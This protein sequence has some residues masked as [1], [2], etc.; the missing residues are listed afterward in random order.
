MSGEATTLP[1]D[2]GRW[3][4]LG[5]RLRRSREYLGLS[6]G[7]V[8]EVL[9][10]SRPAIT[11]IEAGRRK[12]STLELAK[13][14][15]LFGQPYEHFLGEVPELV[16]DETS[17]ALFRAARDLTD[18]DR[19]QVL[20][21][22]Q[23]LRNAGRAP[24]P[25]GASLAMT[26]VAQRQQAR[27]K[28][29]TKAVQRWVQLG[30]DPNFSV[31]IFSVIEDERVWLLF[32]PL[33]GLFGFFDRA[34][35]IAG[36]VIQSKHPVRCSLLTA[37]HE[38]GHYVLGHA[39]SQ[40]SRK[41]LFS[42]AADLALQEIEAQA[43]A[44]E[45]MM[46]LAL[47]NR[48][49]DRLDLP[50]EPRGM[51]AAAAYQLSSSSSPSSYTAALTQLRQL[52][53]LNDADVKRLAKREPIDI[54]MELGDGVKPADS[55]AGAWLIEEGDE[56]PPGSPT[57]GRRTARV[58]L[59]FLERIPLGCRGRRPRWPHAATEGQ[60]RAERPRSRTARGRRTAPPPL[61]ARYEPRKRNALRCACAG[62]DPMRGVSQTCS[63]LL[64]RSTNLASIWKLGRA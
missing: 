33:D 8:A 1:P 24:A 30:L 6:Q 3:R 12:V 62:V 10:I 7:E 64:S 2:E 5:E 21:F 28:G 60:S 35:D 14:A 4:E 13:L 25:E 51:T 48:A 38:Y 46:P 61:V 40:D 16:E 15:R 19:Q 17:Q 55:R 52:N 58:R 9:G 59:R 57:H 32:E 54:K 31:D 42:S 22:A 41:E 49:L 63:T 34:D 50:R 26:T 29:S 36:I 27:L 43:F 47:V 23:F 11:Q 39:Q 45:F 56:T 53:K 20:R 44:A 37:A 18:E